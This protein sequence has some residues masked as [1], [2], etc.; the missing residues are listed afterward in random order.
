MQRYWKIQK[1]RPTH[2]RRPNHSQ[3]CATHMIRE[4]REHA[5]GVTGA[6]L[7][8]NVVRQLQ[9]QK[10][11]G[12]VMWSSGR[13]CIGSIIQSSTA[14]REAKPQLDRQLPAC[15]KRVCYCY[16]DQSVCDDN[17]GQDQ[18]NLKPP[19]CTRSRSR[20]FQYGVLRQPR[21]RLTKVGVPTSKGDFLSAIF[22]HHSRV[23]SSNV[24]STI[25]ALRCARSLSAHIFIF[26]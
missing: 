2:R 17:N 8:A 9:L 23:Q 1:A 15:L 14:E 20:A 10:A 25:G 11:I 26:V 13:M 21:T 18:F 6:V 5:D 16:S 3:D 19:A 12:P 4:H 7:L 22:F 24:T